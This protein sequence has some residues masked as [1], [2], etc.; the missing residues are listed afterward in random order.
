MLRVSLSLQK[1]SYIHLVIVMSLT[2]LTF[3]HVIKISVDIIQKIAVVTL[4]G[5]WDF[6]TTTIINISSSI[7][8]LLFIIRQRSIAS[9]RQHQM[10][11]GISQPAHKG[12]GNDKDNSVVRKLPLSLLHY[13]MMQSPSST[14]GRLRI[15]HA[16]R[17]R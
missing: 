6:I 9:T 7:D 8:C 15:S 2:L 3:I 1:V 13:C 14:H 4:Q 17:R 11:F 10:A 5:D 12:P 16:G